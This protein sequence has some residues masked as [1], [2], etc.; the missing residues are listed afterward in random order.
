MS[1]FLFIVFLL[2]ISVLGDSV[3]IS[4]FSVV[5]SVICNSVVVSFNWV[6]FSLF[7]KEEKEYWNGIVVSVTGL[8]DFW[9]IIMWVVVLISFLF[10][11][12]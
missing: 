3:S 2:R 4:C 8:V 6:S 7:I 5:I 11:I 9:C 12:D 1:Q 10:N